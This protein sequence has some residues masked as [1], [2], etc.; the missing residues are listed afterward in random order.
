VSPASSH[1]IRRRCLST[2]KGK[3]LGERDFFGDRCTAAKKRGLRVIAR[4]S[5]DLNWEDATKAHLEW[6]QRDAQGKLL[7]H[8]EDPRLFRKQEAQMWMDETVASG[9]VPY[10]HLIGAEKGMGEDRRW[11]E[12]GRSFFQWTAKHDPHFVNKQTIANLGVVMGQRT[13]L[14]HTPPG[15]TEMSQYMNGTYCALLEG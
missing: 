15:G 14:F 8:T 10:H 3:Y 9:M 12:T 7:R 1:S 6:F 13:H 11:L 5:P 4:M 2:E